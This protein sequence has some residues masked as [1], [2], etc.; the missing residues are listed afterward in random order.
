MVTSGTMRKVR[1]VKM[2]VEAIRSSTKK[3]NNNNNGNR[4]DSG[5]LVKE[6]L[7]QDEDASELNVYE[8]ID[9]NSNDVVRGSNGKIEEIGGAIK[10][11]VLNLRSSKIKVTHK[12]SEQK[13]SQQGD[14]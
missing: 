3:N 12:A 2:T 10:S 13:F 7:R 11:K 1:S 6:I 8:T 14:R 4:K 9:V 5:S